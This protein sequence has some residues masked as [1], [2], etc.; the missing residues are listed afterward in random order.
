[1]H[2]IA[3]GFRKGSTNSI[4]LFPKGYVKCEIII[5]FV[6]YLFIGNIALEKVS[7]QNPFPEWIVDQ[8]WQDIVKLSE[9]SPLFQDLP[10]Q[11]GK[12]PEEWK[13]W[14]DH[15]NPESVPVPGYTIDDEFMLL[16][17]VRNSLLFYSAFPK[18]SHVFL[19]NVTVTNVS[20]VFWKSLKVFKC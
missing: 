12:N 4:G 7:K 20:R 18:V 13:N 1:M 8:S 16:W 2:Q 9:L 5:Y 17:Y 6:T 10:G 14:F 15:D 19:R 11:I 3:T